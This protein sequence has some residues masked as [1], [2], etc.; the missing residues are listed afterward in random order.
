MSVRQKLRQRTCELHASLD[1]RASR[2]GWFDDL[3][4][5]GGWVSAMHAFHSAISSEMAKVA[6]GEIFDS[7]R[8]E[9]LARDM[10]DL[11]V[12][13]PSGG[14]GAGVDVAGE[15]DGLGVLYVT[16]GATLGARILIKRAEQLGVDG[17]FGAHFLAAEA[18]DFGRWRSVVE[19]LEA[20][21]FDGRDVDRM[22]SAA[23]RTFQFAAECLDGAFKA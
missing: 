2:E 20:S 23:V 10:Q 11:K 8:P 1:A 19:R 17:S 7:A 16:E 15:I 14:P 6:V 4:R 13:P 5:Y 21:A 12:P 18:A 3:H 22:T 9:R